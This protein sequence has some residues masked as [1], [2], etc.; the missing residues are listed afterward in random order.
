M[1]LETDS[2][3]TVNSG[4][5]R[6]RLAGGVAPAARPGWIGRARVVCCEA[7]PRWVELEAAGFRV[8]LSPE[9]P[10][11]DSTGEDGGN[12]RVREEG[13]DTCA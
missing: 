1:A 8:L 2:L 9:E 13:G 10:R 12:G 3:G 11:L 6:M 7:G 5:A 4:Q